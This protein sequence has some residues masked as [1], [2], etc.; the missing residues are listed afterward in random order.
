MAKIVGTHSEQKYY[1][2]CGVIFEY[3]RG[4]VEYDANNVGRV[5]CPQCKRK[6]TVFA[7]GKFQEKAVVAT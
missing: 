4:E 7:D 5:T 2:S 3:I 6:V 1:C